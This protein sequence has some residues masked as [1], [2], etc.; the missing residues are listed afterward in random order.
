MATIAH[1]TPTDRRTLKEMAREALAAAGYRDLDDDV[2]IGPGVTVSAR[3][4]GPDGVE[5]LFEFAG[6]NTPARPGVARIETVWRTI[7]KAAVAG[8]VHPDTDFVVLTCGTVRGGPL[9]AV[10]GDD[11]P[12]RAIVDLARP[13]AVE[14]LIRLDG[15]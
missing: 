1:R 10:T 15:R 3:G 11:A 9:A 6:V 7:A 2:R 4:R 8:E 12:I 5:R 13:D 14:R